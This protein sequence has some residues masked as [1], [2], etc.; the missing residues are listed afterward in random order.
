MKLDAKIIEG[1]SKLVLSRNFDDYKTT[2]ECHREWWEICT[3]S[4]PLVAIAAPR[5]HAKST[6]I[7]HTYTLASVLFKDRRFVVIVSDTYEQAVL[8][9]QDIKK[10]LTA[11]E[12]LQDLFGV[13]KLE[14]DA[15]NDIIVRLADGGRFRIIAKGAEQK[16]RGLKWDGLRPDLIICDDLE[17]DEIVLNQERREK[18]RQWFFKALLPCRSD[19]GIVRIVGTIL[20][21]DSLLERLMPKDW[22]RKQLEQ[23]IVISKPLVSYMNPT[24]RRSSWLSYRYR[25][26]TPDFDEILWPSMWPKTRLVAERQQYIDIGHPEGYSQEYLNYPIDESV[27]FFRRE[28]FLPYKRQDLDS[29]LLKNYVACDLAVS[30]KSRADYS[31]FVVGSLDSNGTL[32]IRDLIRERM[33]AKQIV[34]TL[35]SLHKRYDPEM[36]TLEGSLIEKSIG[37]FLQDEMYRK[38][39]YFNV[40]TMNPTKD[41][42]TRARSIQARMRAG[43]VRF[44]RE[45]DWFGDLEQEMRQFPKSRHDDQVDA[46]AWLGLT[47]DKMVD[48]PTP[49]EQR[50]AD[51]DMA[52]EQSGL[53]EEGRDEDTGY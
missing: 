12:D 6:A 24:K 3:S 35:F 44:D 4:H 20:H 14:K 48:A 11:N 28:D 27:A 41:K 46:I 13:T 31:V 22:D 25:A 38:G 17:N 33:D 19:R 7:T 5:G 30:E 51:Y 21:L 15:E 42:E 47:L 10:E 36:T 34:D 43:G 23:E 49:L 40:N 9:L 29:Q 1:F 2:P 37:P 16:M 26:H 32:Y 18:F 45:A 53:F 39:I 52:Y 8:F 50:E